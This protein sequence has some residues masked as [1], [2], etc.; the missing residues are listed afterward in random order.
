MDRSGRVREGV[1]EIVVNNA[2]VF[3]A[4]I[5]LSTEKWQ[6]RSFIWGH[7]GNYPSAKSM[8]E[9]AVSKWDGFELSAG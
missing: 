9:G 4:T 1:L 5:N 6:K 7:Q 8:G 2:N 3:L